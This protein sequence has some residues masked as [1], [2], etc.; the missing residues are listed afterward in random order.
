MLLAGKK[1]LVTGGKRNIGRGIAL[2]LAEAG[3]DVGINDL[4]RDGEVE[5]TLQ[6]IRDM[7]REASCFEA[8]ISRAVQVASM[9]SAF[10]E[11]FGGID[12]LVNN[13]YSG[14][15]QPF[16]SPRP[17]GITPWGCA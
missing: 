12:I 3:C 14:D 2:A 11:A 16:L 8:D 15:N 6:L 13:P 4:E 17:T 5:E 9:T 10:V 1:A 7:G